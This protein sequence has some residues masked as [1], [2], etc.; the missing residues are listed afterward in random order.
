MAAILSFA[1]VG[2]YAVS[3]I[4]QSMTNKYREN[5]EKSERSKKL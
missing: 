2:I 1:V 4:H 3:E 5:K